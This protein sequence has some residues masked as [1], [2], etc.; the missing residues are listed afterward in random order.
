M[1]SIW[2]KLLFFNFRSDF[3]TCSGA[4]LLLQEFVLTEV[5]LGYKLTSS[6]QL[7]GYG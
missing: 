6:N 1:S 5:N 3:A 2:M 7:R 4:D